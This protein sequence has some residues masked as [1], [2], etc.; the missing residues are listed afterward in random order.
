MN[1]RIKE[2]SLLVD[3]ICTECGHTSTYW[4]E[5]GESKKSNE[6]S[7]CGT[8]MKDTYDVAVDIKF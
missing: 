7:V 6:C 3:C 5:T 2:V 4:H 8:I 1:R